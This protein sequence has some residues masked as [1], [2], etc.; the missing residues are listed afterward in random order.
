MAKT[1]R[2]PL[3]DGLKP[4]DR[5][6]EA[7]FVYRGKPAA[8]ESP[9]AATTAAATL[10]KSAAAS[11]GRSPVTTRIRNDMA[12]ALKRASLERQLAKTYPNTVQDILEEALE[13]WLR[14]N[15]YLQ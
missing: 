3:I 6:Q 5:S 13:P 12:E 1:E 15:G 14:A 4:V 9:P 2:R 7:E 10:D 8:P 11:Q